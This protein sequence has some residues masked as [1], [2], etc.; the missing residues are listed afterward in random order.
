MKVLQ[1][2]LI[3]ILKPHQSINI[4]IFAIPLLNLLLIIKFET[5]VI[6]L[7]QFAKLINRHVAFIRVMHTH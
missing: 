5:C 4:T 3:S 6:P 1:L 7:A 2:N